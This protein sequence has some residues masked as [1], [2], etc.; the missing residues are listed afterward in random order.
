MGT[1]DEVLIGGLIVGGNALANN[2]VV[3]R[4]IGPSLSDAGVSNP[5]QDPVLE[6]HNSSG[7][8]ISSNDDW[9]D[10]Q[11]DQIIASGLAPSNRRESAIFATLPAGNY[12]AVVRGTGDTSG[13]ALVEVYSLEH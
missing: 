13:V 4:A 10:T 12:T 6:L 2:S 5:L 1:A 8:I 9:Q 7:V 11:K 3:L